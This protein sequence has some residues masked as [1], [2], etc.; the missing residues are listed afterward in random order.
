MR[1]DQ[2]RRIF[3]LSLVTFVGVAIFLG[4][5]KL[6]IGQNA[7]RITG[8]YTNMYFNK[9]GGDVLGEEIKIVHT[10]SGYQGALQFAEGEPEELVIVEVKVNGANIVFPIPDS[11]P[12]AGE[13][14]GTVT[15]EVLQGEF[16]FKSGGREK[17]E[18]RKGKSYWD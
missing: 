4:E 2:V 15:N 12:H 17:V 14:S 9:E 13:F 18:L 3:A 8:T 5:P 6:L 16:R 10:R 11:D 7:Q 1:L